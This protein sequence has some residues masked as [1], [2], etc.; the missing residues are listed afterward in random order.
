MSLHYF[1]HIIVRWNNILSKLFKY[2]LAANI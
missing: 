1:Q 2:I